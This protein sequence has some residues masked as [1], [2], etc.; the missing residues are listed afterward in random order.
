MGKKYFVLF[1]L[2]LF[3]TNTEAQTSFTLKPELNNLPPY[4][5]ST[6]PDTFLTALHP[7]I[8][9]YD[10]F[11]PDGDAL[12]FSLESVTPPPP[13]DIIINM[14]SLTGVLTITNGDAYDSFVLIVSVTD[15]KATVYD[16]SYTSSINAEYKGDAN[17]NAV[18]EASDAALILRYVAGIWI[19]PPLSTPG[20][21]FRADADNDNDIT[22]NDAYYILYYVVFT[23][24]PDSPF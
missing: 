9:D 10:A 4:F 11:D 1:I 23:K 3:K 2:L 21:L 14:D 22:A 19:W 16:T 15:G 13:E 5:T 8:F 24:F 7:L 6:L 17:H 12:T 20:D 18:I